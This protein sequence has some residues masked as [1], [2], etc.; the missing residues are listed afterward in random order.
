MSA[1]RVLLLVLCI[2]FIQQ[3]WASPGYYRY[4][5]LHGDTLVFTAEGDL[6]KFTLGEQYAQR[7]TTHPNE[8]REAHISNDG[9][10]I[11]FVANYT[12]SPEIYIMPIQGGIAKR[13]TFENVTVKNHGWSPDGKVLYSYNGR[14]GPIGNWTLKQL[15]PNTLETNT[16]P[17]S[18]AVEGTIATNNELYFVQFGLQ[19]STDN[20]R[21]YQGG[22]TGELWK[23]TLSSQ[24]EAS[25]L[26]KKHKGSIRN[27]MLAD[28]EIYFISNQSGVDNLWSMK[29]NGKSQTQL[30]HFKDWEIRSANIYQDKIVFQQGADIKLF[31]ISNKQTKTLDISLTSDFAHLRERWINKPLDYLTSASQAASAKKVVLTARGRV[32]IANTDNSRL[33]E[34][35][36]PKDSRTRKAILSHNNQWVYALND[37]SGEI[38]VWQYPADGSEGSKQLTTDGQLFRWNLYLSPDGKTLVHDD[39][40]GDLWL[41]DLDTLSNNKLLS[42][43]EG[44]SPVASLTWSK[45]SQLIALSY[46]GVKAERGQIMLI[47]LAT[48]T[49]KLLTTE[50]Y[51]SYSPAFSD[52]SKWLYFLSDREFNSYPRSPWGDRNM[53]PSFDRRTQVFAISLKE[54]A[55]FPFSDTNELDAETK[56]DTTDSKQ[57]KAD[58]TAQVKDKPQVDWNQI[59]NRL[60]Q[61][62]VPSGNYSNLRANKKYLYLQDKVSEPNTKP[63]LKAIEIKPNTK[64]STFS[65]SVQNYTLSSDGNTLFIRR[66]DSKN[67]MYLVKAAGK[68][69]AS[70]SGSRVLTS[71]W[72]LAIDPALEWQQIFHDAWLMH[73]D[74]LFDKNMRGL[75]WAA[76]KQKYQP[77]LSRL[78]HRNELNDIFE[79]M[80]GELNALHS[81][82]R[83]G[84]MPYDKNA[85]QQA[86]LGAEYQQTDDGLK[87]S[88][89]YQNDPELIKRLAPL[90]RPDVNAKNGDIITA[91]NGK[92]IQ[93]KSDLVKALQNQ[94]GKQVLLNLKRGDKIIKTVVK[95]GSK[96]DAIFQ[97]Y[98]DWTTYNQQ[99]VFDTDQNLGY[100]HLYAMGANDVSTFAREFYAQYKKQGLIID[101]RRNRGGNVD[102]WLI[103]K[104]LRRA[105][106]FWQ[107]PGQEANTNM[108]QT[109]RG[110]L[111]I[112][113]DEYTYSDGETF[114]AGVKALELGT[115]IGKQTAGAGVWLTGRNRQADKGIARVAEFPVFAM[116]GRWITEGRGISPDIEVSNLPYATYN[117]E[118]A[119]LEAA[120]KYLQKQIKR[121]PVKT[122]QAKPFPKVN[123]PAEDIID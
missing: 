45:D 15:D 93:S 7:L 22:A 24:K 110:H 99:K 66:A 58:E 19:V 97:R 4:P 84:D 53:G 88:H 43:N 75:D 92:L 39:K 10:W 5:T 23:F 40:N 55:K 13:L 100:L 117:G 91:I 101:V 2:T 116:D 83:G 121:K 1:I 115:V 102:S 56:K 68:F 74:S 35:A 76:V 73:R 82:V 64:I 25:P 123:T 29:L 95:A 71:A 61:V 37:S 26:S 63:S 81:Q 47:E 28:D 42:G 38:E 17:L 104:L 90:A 11:T 59:Q 9:Q 108:Q 69:P 51:A 20:A 119:Q 85:P 120:I 111:V 106:S 89:I 109:F 12:D 72:K 18:D 32:A 122:L 86:S 30:T 48:N 78:T 113:A 77:L 65:S 94:V 62:P 49:Q 79:Q 31:D 118:D 80:M 52:D 14:I 27:T 67:S 60:W 16:L 34:I 6:W 57:D 54:D 36:T 8:E 46:S 105:W 103:E 112:L 98:Y 44:N 50:K 114:T 33:V 70:T 41:L 87:I 107:P 3:A 96:R 21:A